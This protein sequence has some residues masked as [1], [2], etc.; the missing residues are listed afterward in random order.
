MALVTPPVVLLVPLAVPVPLLGLRQLVSGLSAAPPKAV[1][2]LVPPRL[3][4]LVNHRF[5]AHLVD[6]LLARFA[7]LLPI[8][9]RIV[10]R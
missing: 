7:E 1:A 6:L 9:C 2:A 10:L 3:R 4:R 5:V 8:C